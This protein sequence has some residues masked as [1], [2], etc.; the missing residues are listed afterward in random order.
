MRFGHFQGQ[1]QEGCVSE[2]TSYAR[3]HRL[4]GELVTAL[5]RRQAGHHITLSGW[6]N[7]ESILRSEAVTEASIAALPDIAALLSEVVWEVDVP[8]TDYDRE[9]PDLVDEAL[10]LQSENGEAQVQCAFLDI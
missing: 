8:S 5:G 9:R 4:A 2:P 3:I 1:H 6:V 7:L 10:R